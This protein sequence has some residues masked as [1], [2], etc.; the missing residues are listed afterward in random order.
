MPNAANL[1]LAIVLPVGIVS[2]LVALVVS[3]WLAGRRRRIRTDPIEAA[4][5]R[6][7]TATH[8]TLY[9]KPEAGSAATTTTAITS[10]SGSTS[11]TVT[12][13]PERSRSIRNPFGSRG[14]S[15]NSSIGNFNE[16][17][18]WDTERD[19]VLDE[20]EWAPLE[21]GWREPGR[22]RIPKAHH[23]SGDMP[24]MSS[25]MSSGM[26]MALAPPAL[27]GGGNY[28]NSGHA[29]IGWRHGGGGAGGRSMH[30]G[31][32]GSNQT[33]P[34]P[35]VS[36]NGSSRGASVYGGGSSS[37]LRSLGTVPEV[38]LGSNIDAAG[39]PPKIDSPPTIEEASQPA[40]TV[41]TAAAPADKPNLDA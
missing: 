3:A 19:E 28:S 29:G 16:E 37:T 24:G 33:R 18:L 31:R 5:S 27:D 41:P 7:W 20:R 10:A 14:H 32:P 34:P 40:T 1:A 25:R 30:G 8:Q 22:Q 39:L 17:D 36:G 13:V 2:L 9:G 26:G 23:P 12:S 4:A 11:P 6:Q 21:S 38:P 15:R 35:S